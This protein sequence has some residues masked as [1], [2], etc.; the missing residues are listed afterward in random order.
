[1]SEPRIPMPAEAK[2]RKAVAQMARAKAFEKALHPT[3]GSAST[4]FGWL[5]R[6]GVEPNDVKPGD[7]EILDGV[8]ETLALLIE[9]VDSV[10]G[11]GKRIEIHLER[12]TNDK[13]ILSRLESAG[14][15]KRRSPTATSLELTDLNLL[16]LTSLSLH[17]IMV[18]FGEWCWGFG[19]DEARFLDKELV[20]SGKV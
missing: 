7:P 9:K 5:R 17:D 19:E 14:I 13:E 18:W 3:D 10:P 6:F 4:S 1:M 11:T 16:E 20:R 2:Q 8:K 15:L 12:F